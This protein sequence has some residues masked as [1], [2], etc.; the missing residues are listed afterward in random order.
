MI[1]ETITAF[2]DATKCFWIKYKNRA[3]YDEKEPAVRELLDVSDGKDTVK[4]YLEEEKMLKELPPSRNVLAGD[5]LKASVEGILGEGR[6]K[7]T[8]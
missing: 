4:I 2:K 1:A 7:I 6:V 8:W 3:E 5:E